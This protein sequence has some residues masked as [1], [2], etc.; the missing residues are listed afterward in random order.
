MSLKASN[1]SHPSWDYITE[2]LVSFNMAENVC[3]AKC[4]FIGKIKLDLVRF[5][6][7]NEPSLGWN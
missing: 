2:L 5:L 3:A 1:V 4:H 7:K 6:E